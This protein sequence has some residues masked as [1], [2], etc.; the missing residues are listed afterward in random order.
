MCFLGGSVGVIENFI[1]QSLGVGGCVGMKDFC[2]ELNF[3]WSHR[4]AGIE[5]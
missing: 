2:D 4:V 5:R 3:G 1:W